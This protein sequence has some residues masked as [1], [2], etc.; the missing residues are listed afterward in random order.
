MSTCLCHY[1]RKHIPGPA[2]LSPCPPVE[3]SLS[4]P[5]QLSCVVTLQ[6]RLGGNTLRDLFIA[7]DVDRSGRLSGEEVH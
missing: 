4:C 2:H 5:K 3:A 6:H 1:T 7:A